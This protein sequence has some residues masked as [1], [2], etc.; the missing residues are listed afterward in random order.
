[1]LSCGMPFDNHM[2][3][4]ALAVSVTIKSQNIQGASTTGTT[5]L[6]VGYPNAI[7]M[8]GYWALWAPS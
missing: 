3:F 7:I 2:A 5:V 8:V 6:I 4:K 1:M